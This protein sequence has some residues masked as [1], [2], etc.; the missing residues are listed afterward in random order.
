MIK[1][2]C[3]NDGNRPEDFPAS[4]WLKKDNEYHITHVYYHPEQ[5][6]QGIE[7]A[8]INMRDCAPYVSFKIDRFAIAL[9]DLEKLLELIKDCNDLSDIDIDVNKLIEELELC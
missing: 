5:Q 2:K 6:I 1:T 9:E 7:V 8:E 4:K 3:I